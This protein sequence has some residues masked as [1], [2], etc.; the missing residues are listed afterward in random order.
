MVEDM[1][2]VTAEAMAEATVEAMV[3]ATVEDMVEATV[4]E[5]ALFPQYIRRIPEEV[6]V[7]AEVIQAIITLDMAPIHP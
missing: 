1:A 3:E 7:A 5:V 2:E 4:V 6:M